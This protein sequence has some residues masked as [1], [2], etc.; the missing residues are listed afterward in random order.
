MRQLY[1]IQ[2]GNRLGNNGMGHLNP[3]AVVSAPVDVFKEGE[4]ERNIKTFILVRLCVVV[5]C[6][7]LCCRK[8]MCVIMIIILIFDD[9]A[10]IF[11]FQHFAIC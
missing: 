5:A 11:F 4:R 6:E 8:N 9:I 7:F 2:S 3:N 10:E 1:D